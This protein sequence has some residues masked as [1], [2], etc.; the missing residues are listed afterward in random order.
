MFQPPPVR[1]IIFGGYEQEVFAGYYEERKNKM[2]HAWRRCL[3]VSLRE[4][5]AGEGRAI[6]ERELN[7]VG[8]RGS[9]TERVDLPEMIPPLRSPNGAAMRPVPLMDSLP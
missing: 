4:G 6:C 9:L 7:T 1:G 5:Y 8:R 3:L 2:W